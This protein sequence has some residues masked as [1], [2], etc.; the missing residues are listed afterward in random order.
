[1]IVPDKTP[2]CLHDNRLIWWH[3]L[4][5]ANSI[6]CDNI[7][8]TKIS[9]VLELLRTIRMPCVIYMNDAVNKGLATIEHKFYILQKKY[10]EN[11]KR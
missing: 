9:R 4:I 2:A 8:K 7:V 3:Y 1:M 11:S 10:S 6:K 5:K